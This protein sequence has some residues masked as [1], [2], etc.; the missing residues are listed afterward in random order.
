MPPP[1][2]FFNPALFIT[3]LA[4][5]LIAV[6]FCILIYF[7]TKGIYD[8]S[9]YKGIKYFRHAFLFLGLSYILRF[10]L[11]ILMLSMMTLDLRPRMIM[12]FFILI[13]GYF[14][15]AGILY[16]VLS[17]V[18][19]KVKALPLNIIIHGTA[20][21]LS[22]AAFATRSHLILLYLQTAL[23]VIAVILNI[24]MHKKLSRMR[25]IYYLI[26][27]LWLINLW[28]IDRRRLP[29]EINIVFQL[30]SLIVFYFIYR[31]ISKFTP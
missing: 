4:F 12:P 20:L 9:K 25:I 14:S 29:F 2:L 16:L 23:L 1:P 27:F 6:I 28:I 30:V 18:W 31:K 7:R 22:I 17:S 5:T 15:T 11:S 13:T 24:I 8:L 26:F 21:I 19:K 3:E 10:L